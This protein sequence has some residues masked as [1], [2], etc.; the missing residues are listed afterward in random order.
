MSSL[1][2][3]GC[4]VSGATPRALEAFERA[5]ARWQSWRLGAE[6]PLTQALELAPD[7]VMAHVLQAYLLTLGR[8]KKRVEA[9]RPVLARAAALHANSRERLHLRAIGA[10]L[11]RDD[12]VSARAALGTLL[13][14]EPRDVIALQAAQSLDY[15]SGD[16]RMLKRRA[17]AVLPAWSN[18][19][20]GYH[21]VLAMHAFGLEEG[22]AYRRAEAAAR[23]ALRLD[24]SD[25][26]AHHV[27]AHIFEMTDR[28]VDGERWLIEHAEHWA[29]GTV[30]ATHGWWHL[31]LFQLAQ[32]RV[33]SALALYERRIRATRSTEIADMIDASALLW[34]IGLRGVDAGRRWA[35]L[36]DAWAPH[37][38][39][40]YCSFN[41]LHAALAF[42][43]AARWDMV[44]RLDR[45]LEASHSALT[46]HGATTRLLGLAACRGIA[47]FGRGDYRRAARLLAQLPAKAHRFGGSHAQRDVLHLTQREAARRLRPPSV[48][49]GPHWAW[50]GAHA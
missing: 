39:D 7:F 4:S 37:V 17:A 29:E 3:R 1:D 15:V 36:A 16:I 8:D 22:G 30:V 47:A 12:L 45:N 44:E 21:A 40:L 18:A 24:P 6:A 31:A 48:Q 46:R 25:A 2:H 10:V 38:D 32:G 33:Q 49:L 11:D 14:E 27:M 42:V 35:E 20:P 26:R 9:A 43:G 50:K 13:R 5:V 19:L 34:R 23:A 41:D 28:P